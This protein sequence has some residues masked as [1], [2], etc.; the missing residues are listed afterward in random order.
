MCH[1]LSSPRPSEH[2]WGSSSQSSSRLQPPG[3]KLTMTRLFFVVPGFGF[4][5]WASRFG[6]GTGGWHNDN[7]SEV[8]DVSAC[9]EPY[10]TPCS[11]HTSPS[12]GR[13]SNVATSVAMYMPA[14]EGRKGCGARQLASPHLGQHRNVCRRPTACR[15][16]RD[17][18]CDHVWHGNGRQDDW[19]N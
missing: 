17:R 10:V 13:L 7:D 16:A 6:N 19:V 9:G 14:D 8:G 11:S 2:V 15:R 4:G 5:C 12:V 3:L 1:H 18:P